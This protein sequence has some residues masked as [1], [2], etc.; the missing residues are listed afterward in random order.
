MYIAKKIVL[1][2]CFIFLPFGIAISWHIFDTIVKNLIDDFSRKLYRINFFF[3]YYIES[4]FMQFFHIY[5]NR[6]HI[7]LTHSRIRGVWCILKF[8]VVTFIHLK[9]LMYKFHAVHEKIS[10]S[11]YNCSVI[12][13]C[14]AQHINIIQCRNIFIKRLIP[15]IIY[16]CNF[17]FIFWNAYYW[18][19]W[20]WHNS[21]F[22]CFYN[23]W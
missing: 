2:C 17:I 13:K 12:L 11:F 1:V 14:A 22:L 9:A 6:F 19:Y 3:D 16:F 4:A 20:M 7:H 15:I 21:P 8:I 18:R 5:H 10:C 23:I